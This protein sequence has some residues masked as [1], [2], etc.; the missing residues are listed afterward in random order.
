[1]V[2]WSGSAKCITRSARDRNASSIASM[3]L[4][5][6]TKS[7]EGSLRATSSIPSMTASVA[8]WTSTGLVSNEAV[9]RRTAKLSTSSINT[10]VKGRRAAIS[11]IV[12]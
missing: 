9:L 8:R 12:S 10:T 6:V 3:K 5:V 1:M 7:T 4:V 11:G 2:A